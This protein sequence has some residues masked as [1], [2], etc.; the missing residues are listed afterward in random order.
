MFIT[1]RGGSRG[2][3]SSHLSGRPNCDSLS[4]IIH[5]SA[6]ARP[7]IVHHTSRR[8]PGRDAFGTECSSHL[9]ALKCDSLSAIIHILRSRDR[10]LPG[11]FITPLG[12]LVALS[13]CYSLSAIIHILP[14]PG[15]D[16]VGREETRN[17]RFGAHT[18]GCGNNTTNSRE[19]VG[20]L[21]FF[22]FSWNKMDPAQEQGT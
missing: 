5:C 9:S 16:A 7:R 11:L 14:S 21:L 2:Y 17:N 18:E 12:L 6:L 22:L 13:I 10:G 15:P 4:A 8:R 3:C 20:D 19:R 1:P